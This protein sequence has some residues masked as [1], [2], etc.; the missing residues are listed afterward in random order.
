[1]E[2]KEKVSVCFHLLDLATQLAS[3][4]V[5]YTYRLINSRMSDEIDKKVESQDSKT[6]QNHL[7]EAQRL[8]AFKK[9]DESAEEYAVALDKM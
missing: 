8:F 7:D 9:Y 4:H 1:M 6:A 5:T 2:K 3:I